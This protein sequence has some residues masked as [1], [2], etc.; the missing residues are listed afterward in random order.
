MYHKKQV[1][2]LRSI[3]S[4]IYFCTRAASSIFMHDTAMECKLSRTI[5]TRDIM[6]RK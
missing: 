4:D 5:S 2:L 6:T 3:R 1:L